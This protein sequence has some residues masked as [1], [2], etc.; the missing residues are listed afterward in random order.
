METK[1][2]KKV[3]IHA[4][5]RQR[6]RTQMKNSGLFNMSD[7]HF[8]EYLLTFVI[9]R[10]DTNPIAHALLKEFGS[11]PNIFTASPHALMQVKG[12]GKQTAEFLQYMSVAVYMYNKSTASKITKLDTL[13]NMVEYI[14]RVLKPSETEQFIVI[15][16][17]KNYGVKDFKTFEGVSHSFIS[18]NQTELSEFLINHKSGFIIMAHTHPHHSAM[19]SLKDIDMFEKLQPLLDALSLVI[20]ENIIIGDQDVYSLKNMQIYDM[21]K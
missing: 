12:I 5:H 3:N 14:K 1:K 9:K 13:K 18:I 16:L 2:I 19:P 8:L 15:S 21:P 17:N 20:V 7:L 6:M 11:I 4:G 10:S